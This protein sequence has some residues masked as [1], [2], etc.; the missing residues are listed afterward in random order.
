MNVDARTAERRRIVDT[1]VLSKRRVHNRC[2][3]A[4][5][6]EGGRAVCSGQMHGA[7]VVRDDEGGA[8]EEGLETSNGELTGEIQ[9]APSRQRPRR[10]QDFCRD[11][12][13]SARAG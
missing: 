1:R 8:L 7:A 12:P 2:L 4:K 3:R 6:P 13:L 5:E 9:Q 10:A 11:R